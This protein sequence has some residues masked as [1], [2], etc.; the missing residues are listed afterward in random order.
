[1]KLLEL[2]ISIYINFIFRSYYIFHE[3]ALSF[4][5]LGEARESRAMR[6]GLPVHGASGPGGGAGNR[7]RQELRLS[8][9]P[10]TGTE[11]GRSL[12]HTW[13]P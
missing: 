5:V 12:L 9:F 3:R 6:R 10:A 2:R 1:M 13:Q 8:V 4:D 11:E 7:W